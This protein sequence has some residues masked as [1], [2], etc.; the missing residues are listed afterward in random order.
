MEAADLKKWEQSFEA[1]HARFSAIFARSESREQACKY[2]R[3]LLSEA[4]RKNGWQVAESIGDGAP[5][6]TQRLLY[7]AQWDADAARDELRRYIVEALGEAEGI[8]I[9]DETGFLKKG[10]KSV[11]VKRQYTGTAGKIENSQVGTFL[12]YASR[13]GH[14]LLDRRLFLPEEW[15]HD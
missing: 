7:Q 3:G 4:E 14:T 11:G 13:R 1:F 15:A 8:G 9:V 2:V 5:D 6:K 12:A 10:M